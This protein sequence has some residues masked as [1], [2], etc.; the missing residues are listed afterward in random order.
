MS[1]DKKAALDKVAKALEGL[2]FEKLSESD[3]GELAGG[4]S[5]ALSED[6]LDDGG[7]TINISKCHCETQST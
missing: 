3:A 7:I 4:F 5:S 1:Q 6:S 2:D